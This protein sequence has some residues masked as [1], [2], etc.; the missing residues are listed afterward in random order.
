MPADDSIAKKTE[1]APFESKKKKLANDPGEAWHAAEAL[2]PFLG[3]AKVQAR[4]NPRRRAL[5]NVEFAGARGDMRNELNCA[6]A[7]ANHRDS[8]GA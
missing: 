6:R 7:G 4:H 1:D 2:A 3:N 5:E 8:L